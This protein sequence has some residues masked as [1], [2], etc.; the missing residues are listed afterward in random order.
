MKRLIAL[1]GAGAAIAA[2]SP[3]M[4]APAH[5]NAHSQT[6]TICAAIDQF[7]SAHRQAM[8]N[9]LKA[10]PDAAAKLKAYEKTN[11]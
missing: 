9:W 5:H 8:H 4:A 2:A 10:H 6:S 3:A 11:C 1:A 7:R